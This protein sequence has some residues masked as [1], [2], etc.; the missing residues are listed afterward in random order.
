M[1]KMSSQARFAEL[2]IQHTFCYPFDS[3]RI[4]TDMIHL[5]LQ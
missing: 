1:S 3:S 4:L 5:F 2:T